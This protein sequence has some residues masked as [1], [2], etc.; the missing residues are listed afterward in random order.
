MTL[1]NGYLHL[2][3][4]RLSHFLSSEIHLKQ[5]ISCLINCVQVDV[6]GMSQL[7]DP[8]I[9]GKLYYFC[10]PMLNSWRVSFLLFI[11]NKSIAIIV[12]TIDSY[13][14]IFQL[15]FM[16]VDNDHWPGN[17]ACNGYTVVPVLRAYIPVCNN[18][19]IILLFS[20]FQWCIL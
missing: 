10:I 8:S 2:L 6:S 15:T 16:I 19:N 20:V 14:H 7:C 17:Y 13:C 5:L 11:K 12:Y 4:S 18:S 3:E 1:L 9:R